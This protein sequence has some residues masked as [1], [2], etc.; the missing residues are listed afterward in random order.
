M[1]DVNGWKERFSV[2]NAHTALISPFADTECVRT[3]HISIIILA[4]IRVC[5]SQGRESAAFR[6]MVVLVR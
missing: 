3:T 1:L 6:K 4:N 5:V 2:K